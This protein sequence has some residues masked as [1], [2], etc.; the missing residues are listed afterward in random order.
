[1]RHQVEHMQLEMEEVQ[2]QHSLANAQLDAQLR[3]MDPF[4][5]ALMHLNFA[6]DKQLQMQHQK[7]SLASSEAALEAAHQQ[8]RN[9]HI[10]IEVRVPHR[11]QNLLCDSYSHLP[12]PQLQCCY[13]IAVHASKQ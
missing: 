6:P 2:Q 9:A 8:L 1:M 3:G 10:E 12:R 7:E 11:F 13:R 5:R 4:A